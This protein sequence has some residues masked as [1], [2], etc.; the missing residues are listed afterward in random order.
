MDFEPNKPRINKLVGINYRTWQIQV[1]RMIKAQGLYGAINGRF[2]KILKDLAKEEPLHEAEEEDDYDDVFNNTTIM[3]AKASTLIMGLCSQ[4]PLDHIISLETAQEQ[5]DKLK[6]LYAPLGLQQLESKTQS[7]INYEPRPN[8]TIA[9]VSNELDTLQSEIG[10]ISEGERPSDTMKLTVLYRSVRTLNTLY[11]PVVLQLGLAKITNYEEVIVQLMEYERRISA[12][13]KTIKEN[14]FSAT[15]NRGRYHRNDKSNNEDKSRK[16]GFNGKCYNCDKTGHRRADCRSLPKNERGRAS[17]GPLTTP[18]GGRGLSPGDQDN[19]Y[20]TSE[21]SWMASTTQTEPRRNNEL[22]WVVDSGCSRHMTYSR[23]VLENFQTLQTPIK[24]NIANGTSI[25]AI[26]EGSARLKI[27]IHGKT[28]NVLLHNV[29]YVPNLAGSLISVIQLQD[30]GILTHTTKHGELLLE[31]DGKVI[32]RAVRVGKTYTLASTVERNESAYSATV[33][34][35]NLTWHR[36][37][38]HL[39]TKTLAKA[40]QA[41]HGL[42]KPITSL[43]EPCEIC[44]QSKMIRSINRQPPERTLQ[45]LGRIH[46]DAWG[47]YRVPSITGDKYFFSFTDDYSRK[48]WVY[49]TNARAKLHDIFTEFKIKVELESGA[50]IKAVR[51]DN[52]S[53]YKALATKFEKGYGIQFEFTTTYTPEQ[54][55]VSERLNR[56]LVT[57]ARTMLADAKLPA[58]FWAE[59]IKTACYLRNRTPIGPN[60]RTPEE[61]YTGNKPSVQHLRAWG[62]V[63]YAHLPPINRDRGDK[64]HPTAVKT[65]LTGYMPTTRQYRLFDPLKEAFIISTAPR[66]LENQRLDIDWKKVNPTLEVVQF[67]PTELEFN[68]SQIDTQQIGLRTHNTKSRADQHDNN[69]PEEPPE[70]ADDD[71]NDQL[72]HEASQLAPDNPITE[73]QPSAVNLPPQKQYRKMQKEKQWKTFLKEP[74]KD[75]QP[76]VM[77]SRT[78][79]TRK[80]P[81][82]GLYSQTTAHQT[83]ALD[84]SELETDK[85]KEKE[86]ANGGCR[87]HENAYT[88]SIGKIKIPRS[89]EEAINDPIYGPEWKCAVSTEL[90]TLQSLGTWEY[91]ALPMGKRPVGHK[92]VFTVKY[93]PTGQLDKFKARLTAQGFSQ[94]YGD[95]FLETFSPTMRAESL[96]VLLAIAAHEDLHIR[97]IDVVSAYPRSKLHA[98]V[99]MKPPKGLECPAGKVLKLETSLYGLKQSGREW[100]IEACHGLEGIGLRPT[101]IEPSVFTLEDRSLI[102]GLYVD[103]MIILSAD[104]KSV[105]RV[106]TEI[107]KLWDIKDMG[108][109]SK[110]LGLHIHRDRVR[111]ALTI[112]QTSYIEETLDKF[113][114][115]N[116]KPA[117]LPVSDRNTLIA[118]SPNERHADQLLYQQAIGRLMWISNSTRF[119][120]SY[121]VGQLSQHCNK[122][123]I[124]HWNGV[125]Q[126]FRYLSGTRNLKL[127]LG[128]ESQDEA[129]KSRNACYSYKLHGFSD[130]DYAGDQTDRKSVTGHIYLLNKGPVSWSSTKQ[131]CVATSTTEAEYI[132]LSEASKQGQWLRALIKELRRTNLLEDNQAVPMHSDNQACIA[133]SQ[134]PTGHRRTKHID[135]RYHYIRELIAYGKATVTYLATQDMIADILTKPLTAKPFERCIGTLL[136]V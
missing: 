67:E 95:D 12:S 76:E 74:F 89:Y 112:S 5:W 24:I 34:N 11:D 102:L 49:V 127:W 36:R 22:T 39:G 8:A 48:S 88:T 114:L 56:S 108:E 42:K 20:Y 53:E 19:T 37:F 57:L 125:T 10:A 104:K 113:N 61:V 90:T 100:Y 126:V 109:V 15:T 44:I 120:I 69:I 25:E 106:V 46:T 133:I 105:E 132:A 84:T 110:I 75:F 77:D 47:P 72:Q 51:C 45:V 117:G 29:L 27:A 91:V 98:D 134:D 38:G 3:D 63:A 136:H 31:L 28:V 86:Y 122:P 87:S 1:G 130:A 32:G 131:K 59:A 33:E 94:I 101:T 92:W 97:Q 128:G 40:H 4:G 70:D 35:E 26:G 43:S 58:R 13:G 124:R 111:R 96:R 66:F 116:A 60:E 123:A 14:V 82:Q 78:R 62:C 71:P 118:A 16:K 55:G 52:I 83:D 23:D 135:I 121:V 80:V 64:M 103:D 129:P 99:Y 65:C 6:A 68:L 119:D 7:F 18:N 107:K 2:A 93:T 41:T 85:D 81:P 115:T 79:S 9:D 17:T 50:K 54:N 30:R 21:T 73:T